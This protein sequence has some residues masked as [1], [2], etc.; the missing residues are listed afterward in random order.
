LPG[1]FG[2]P[3][4]WTLGPKVL[5]GRPAPGRSGVLGPL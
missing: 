4:G 5:S 2:L 3:A 1:T